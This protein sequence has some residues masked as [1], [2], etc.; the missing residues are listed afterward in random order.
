MR[1]E[2]LSERPMGTRVKLFLTQQG[3]TLVEENPDLLIVAYYPRILKK[4][5]FE[6]V[7]MGAINFHPGLLPYNRGMY[8]H[9]WPLVDGTPAGVT[10]HY[11]DEKVDH[12]D[13]IAQRRIDVTPTD[14]AADLEDKTQKEIF[15]L[16]VETWP[17]IRD[18]KV[19]RKPQEGPGTFH[20]AK[21]IKTIQEFDK[22]TIDRLRAC[23]FRDRSYG[24]YRDG[25]KKVYVGVKFFTEDDIKNF[26]ERNHA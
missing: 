11:I 4:E 9:I 8:P 15:D 14:T 21:E 24:Y 3:E 18:G 2:V 17:D 16:F 6:G 13:I 7:P 10:L 19:K 1:V 22:T 5:E 25:D 12:G 23:T 26:E 20:L